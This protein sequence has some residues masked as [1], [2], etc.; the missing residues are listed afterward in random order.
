MTTETKDHF[1][2]SYKNILAPS[3]TLCQKEFIYGGYTYGEIFELAAGLKKPGKTRYGE[4]RLPVYGKQGGD[5]RFPA[6]FPF[7]GL[8]LD[9]ALFFFHPR[10]DGN[11]RSSR[12]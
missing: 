4:V 1:I 3:K 6:G 8:P 2:S 12:L 10:T 5:R 11:V 7:R 9:S